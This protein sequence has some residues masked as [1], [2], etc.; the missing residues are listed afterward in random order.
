MLT[1]PLSFRNV[2][3]EPFISAYHP[4]TKVQYC[5]CNRHVRFGWKKEALLSLVRQYDSAV[6]RQ[7]EVSEMEEYSSQ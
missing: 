1:A 5:R 4:G 3:D 2:E 7:K 6:T